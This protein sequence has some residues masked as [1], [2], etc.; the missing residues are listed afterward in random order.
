MY[1][2]ELISDDLNVQFIQV[3]LRD[4]ALEVGS[5]R[6]ERER[7]KEGREKAWRKRERERERG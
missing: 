1:L 2:V 4:T 6:R 5:W 7:E 3:S